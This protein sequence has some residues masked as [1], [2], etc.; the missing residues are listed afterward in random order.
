[1]F[2]E[3]I[4][5]Y[6]TDEF[7]RASSFVK[8]VWNEIETEVLYILGISDS[9]FISAHSDDE[10]VI[11]T[12]ANT[13]NVVY[14]KNIKHNIDHIMTKDFFTEVNIDIDYSYAPS[15][16]FYFRV[17]NCCF[18]HLNNSVTF[19][20]DNGEIKSKFI[21]KGD[22]TSYENI[23]ERIFCELS[24][25]VQKCI[26]YN[27]IYNKTFEKYFGKDKYDT[28]AL[29]ESISATYLKENYDFK[30]KLIM[31]LTQ[32]QICVKSYNNLLKLHENIQ[33]S[34]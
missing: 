22:F 20:Q 32:E 16:Q 17:D 9:C 29:Y 21:V 8:E 13:S 3:E 25:E 15:E 2:A 34:L 23:K 33:N 19:Y 28:D 31:L 18:Y 7:F 4:K 24:Y 30:E 26:Q 27:L 1:M 12:V 6:Y 14:T 10:C 11:I 5:E